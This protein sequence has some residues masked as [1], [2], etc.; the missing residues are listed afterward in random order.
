MESPRSVLVFE[1]LVCFIFPLFESQ[2]VIPEQLEFI[3]NGIL[4]VW[5]VELIDRKQLLYHLDLLFGN[6]FQDE[7]RKEKCAICRC[8]VDPTES[9][10][11][12][13]TEIERLSFDVFH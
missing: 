13:R 1:S 10:K 11:S 6:G 9:G 7:N 4:E 8:P 2:E 12:Q 5:K 3:S